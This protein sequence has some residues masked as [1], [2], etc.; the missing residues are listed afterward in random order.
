[1]APYLIHQ[2]EP[3]LANCDALTSYY[4]AWNSQQFSQIF[5]NKWFSQGILFRS[6]ITTVFPAEEI[7]LRKQ[8]ISKQSTG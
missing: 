7:F 5:H 4:L 8:K 6:R 2:T 1:M 3:L